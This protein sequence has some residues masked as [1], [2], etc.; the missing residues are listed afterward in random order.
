M[1]VLVTGGSGF[2]G[3][4]L[5]HALIGAHEVG[6]IDDLSTGAVGNIHPASWF[7]K[8]DITE[9]RLADL[10]AEFRPESIVHLAAQSSVPVSLK[11]PERDWLVN[12]EGT[13]AVAAAAREAGVHRVISASS[14]AVYGDPRQLPLT[15]TSQ[16][17]PLS[18]YGRSKLAAEEVLAAE[19]ASSPVD[20]ASFRF[21]NV[22]GPRQDAQGEGGVVAVF[23]DHLVRGETPT[24]FGSG[25]Q[26]RD[27]IYVGDVVSAIMMALDAHARLREGLGD[28]PAYNIATGTP[29]SVEDLARMLRPISGFTGEFVHA[30]SR[31]GD[32]EHSSLDPGKARDVFAWDA[33]VP[34]EVGL[35]QT[36]RWFDAQR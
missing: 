3:A 30:P 35:A 25:K 36:Y 7:R 19:L 29:T 4:N 21:A 28:G 12:V 8:L 23:C 32:V 26:S 9:S 5:V 10:I 22:Y 6:V 11:D 24:I 27:F 14:A 33:R 31:E 15:E 16:K 2:I 18:P 34:L 20:F 17:L 1:R 13:R